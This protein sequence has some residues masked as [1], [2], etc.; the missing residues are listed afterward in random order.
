[1]TNCRCKDDDSIVTTTQILNLPD[2][3]CS[4]YF[5]RSKLTQYGYRYVQVFFKLN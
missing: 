1:M 5:I 3:P 4:T 2:D